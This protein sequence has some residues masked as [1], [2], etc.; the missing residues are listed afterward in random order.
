VR[1]GPENMAV[2]FRVIIKG[3]DFLDYLRKYELIDESLNRYRRTFVIDI[4]FRF[5]VFSFRV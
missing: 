5:E 3:G 2:T 1:H 4:C